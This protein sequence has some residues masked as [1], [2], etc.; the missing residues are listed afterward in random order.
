MCCVLCGVLC[1]GRE[2]VGK[3]RKKLESGF[4][5]GV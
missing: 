3:R 4:G 2:R 5:F 1:G